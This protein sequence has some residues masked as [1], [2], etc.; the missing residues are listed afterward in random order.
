MME[1]AYE[2]TTT[3]FGNSS[4]PLE[5]GQIVTSIRRLMH[6]WGTNSRYVKE[7]LNLLENEKLIVCESCRAEAAKTIRLKRW[8]LNTIGYTKGNAMSHTLKKIII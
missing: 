7:F 6:R 1:A 2:R 3:R 4:V 5:R 8:S